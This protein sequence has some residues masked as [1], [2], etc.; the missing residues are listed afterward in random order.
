MLQ[1]NYENLLNYWLQLYG[2]KVGSSSW[3]I[4]IIITGSHPTSWAAWAWPPPGPPPCRRCPAPSWCPPPSP[5][6]PRAARAGGRGS[7]GPSGAGGSTCTCL[8]SG[9]SIFNIRLSKWRYEYAYAHSLYY[10]L[11]LNSVLPDD[12]GQQGQGK[13]K[14]SIKSSS[15]FL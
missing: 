10:K 11:E 2:S 13:V 4:I 5:T 12:A 3:C 15:K 8:D 14:S 1:M 9:Y 6:S 7:R